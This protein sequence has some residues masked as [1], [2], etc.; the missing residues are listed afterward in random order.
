MLNKIN[1]FKRKIMKMLT[2][3][4]GQTDFSKL[5]SLNKKKIKRVLILRPNHRLGNLLLITPLVQEVENT[6]PGCT[7]DLFVK[8][9]AAKVIFKN[10]S[11]IGKIIMLPKNHFKKLHKYIGGW[12]S[13]TN[14]RYDIII[15]VNDKSS[16]G[17]LSAQVAKG[18]YVF[19]A[20]KTLHENV[21]IKPADYEHIALY[22]VYDFRNYLQ[23]AGIESDMYATVPLLNLKLSKK[24]LTD[25]KEILKKLLPETTK[26]ISIF[27]YATGPKCLDTSWWDNFYNELKQ[28][29]PDYTIIEILPVEN[30]SQIGFRAPH[31][32]GKDIRK[33]A[34]LIANTAVFIGADSGM[35]HLAVASGCPTVGLFSV[36]NPVTYK[37]YGNRNTYINI[38][39]TSF[40]ECMATVDMTVKPNTV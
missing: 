27:T 5:P 25:G 28:H 12:V 20:S 9:G 31:Y 4:M 36:T 1:E 11:C 18:A 23:E 33:I 16:S 19:S 26:A 38:T 2:K 22:P 21:N 40:S 37:P 14:K 34:A 13:L 35:M 24:E 7:V 39:T 30:V 15:N 32:Y 29:Y 17:K 8:G 10:Y 3:N 6:F